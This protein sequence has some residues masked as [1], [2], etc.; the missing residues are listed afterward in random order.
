MLHR[1]PSSL[2]DR[3][4]AA[5]EPHLPPPRPGG[6]PRSVNLRSIL[7][8]IFYVLKTGCQWR[9]LPREFG[10]WSTVYAYFRRWSID[11]TWQ[12]LHDA[13]R[14]EERA[15]RGRSA[16]PRAMILDSRTAKTAGKGARAATIVRRN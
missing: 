10:P 7:D 4:W 13:L 5:I 14:D 9:Q 6:R 15:R 1:Y 16:N 8:A 12:R 2:S 3:Q 11:G